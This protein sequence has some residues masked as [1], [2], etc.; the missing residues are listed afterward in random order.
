[1]EC[2]CFFKTNFK[3]IVVKSKGPLI[4]SLVCLLVAIASFSTIPFSS[5]ILTK[6][7]ASPPQIDRAIDVL[8]QR[9]DESIEVIGEVGDGQGAINVARKEKP[10]IILMDINIFRLSEWNIC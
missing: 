10:D 6:R 9:T 2:S 1:M 5:Q 8:K 3:E 7:L 4:A